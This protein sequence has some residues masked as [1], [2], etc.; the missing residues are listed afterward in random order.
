[1]INEYFDA[2]VRKDLDTIAEMFHPEVSLQDPFVKVVKGKDAVL[3]IYKSMFAGNN[4]EIE[5][6]RQF[7]ENDQSFAVEFGLTVKPNGKDE[8]YLEGIDLV[9]LKDG[10]IISLRAYLDTN[11]EK[12]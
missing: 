7:K 2:F 5:I 4:F 3:E 12:N 8:Q 9:E 1:M 10:K 11:A 6:K